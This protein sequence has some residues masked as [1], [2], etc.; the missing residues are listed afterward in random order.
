ME[1]KSNT[2]SVVVVTCKKDY[3]KRCLDSVRQQVYSVIEII[4]I[5]N[6]SDKDL[7]NKINQ[8]YK[9]IRLYQN[10]FNL[11][12]CSALNRGIAMARGDFILCLNDDVVL[13]QRF[14]KEALRGF[15]ISEKIGMVSGKILRFNGITID[16]TGLF[17]SPWRTA[18]ERGYGVKDRGQFEKEGYIFGVNGAVAFYRRSM[19][20][21]IKI[22]SD[23]FDSEY[24]IFYEDLD[25]AWR[26][27]LLGWKAY[28]VPEAVARHKRGGS[29][30]QNQGLDKPFARRYLSD[31]LALDLLKNRY[32]T[33][34][35]NE[36]FQGFLLH[37]PFSILYD[38][39]IWSCTLIFRPHLL[40][41]FILKLP[42]LNSALNKRRLLIKKLTF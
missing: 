40:K 34:I 24:R 1:A 33:I 31:E 11:F 39:I 3:L 29:V 26:A 7:A 20:E 25:I 8:F 5:D 30:R 22:G 6:S 38:F 35:K 10:P 16:S 23:Y 18:R 12:Y 32:L 21:G 17:L 27:N 9:E 19:L 37:L 41:E 2:V 4:I 36:S 14:I 42:Y 13:D 15:S 28:Y